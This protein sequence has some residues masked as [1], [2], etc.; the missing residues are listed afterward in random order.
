MPAVGEEGP[1][2]EHVRALEEDREAVG[3]A[4]ACYTTRRLIRQAFQVCR[5][6]VVGRAVLEYVNRRECGAENNEKPFYREQQVKT[7]RK[8][9]GH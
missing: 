8:Y 1:E 9:S 4:E 7:V 2:T 3:L 6:Q 5:L